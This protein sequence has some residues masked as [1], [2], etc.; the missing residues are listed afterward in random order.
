MK[1]DDEFQLE[2]AEVE[3]LFDRLIQVVADPGAEGA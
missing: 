1:N 2:V 3:G